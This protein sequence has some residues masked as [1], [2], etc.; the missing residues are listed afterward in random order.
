MKLTPREMD[1]VFIFC[2]AEMARRRRAR[3]LKLNYPESVAL[4]CDE[5]AEMARVGKPYDE[6][7]N[8]AATILGRNDVLEGVAELVNP[9]QLEVSFDDGTKL[10]TIQNPIR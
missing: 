3:G 4:I 10:L 1:R 6:V 9:L 7:V 8:S 5:L 2:I